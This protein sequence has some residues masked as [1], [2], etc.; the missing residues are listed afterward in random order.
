M[1]SKEGADGAMPRGGGDI[2]AGDRIGPFQVL[3]RIG[4]GGM[5]EVLRARD[6]KLGRDV[7]LKILARGTV[8]ERDLFARFEREAQAASALNHPNIITIFDTGRDGNTAYI[9]MELV[10]GRSLGDLISETK[11]LAVPRILAIAT[12]IADALATAHDKGIVHRDLKPDNVMVTPEGRVKLLDFGLAKLEL[13]RVREPG[14]PDRTTVILADLA[15]TPGTILGT[16]GYMAPEQAAGR[17]TDFRSDQFSFGALLYEMCSGK[18]AFERDSSV[19]TLT[20][21]IRDEPVS[22]HSHRED[23][24]PP[25]VWLVERCLAKQPEERYAS[26]RD[27]YRDLLSLSRHLAEVTGGALRLPSDARTALLAPPPG[28]QRVT[29][30]GRLSKLGPSRARVALLALGALVLGGALGALSYGRFLE[31]RAPGPPEIRTL[32]FSGRDRTPAVSPDG[33][34]VA[35][36]S[37]RDGTRRIWLKQIAG[38]SEAPL[39]EGPDDAWPG[40]SPDGASV[41]FHRREASGATSIFRAAVVGGEVRRILENGQFPSLSPDGRRLAFV[42]LGEPRPGAPLATEVWVSEADGTSPKRVSIEPRVSNFGPIWSPDGAQLCLGPAYSGGA[43]PWGIRLLDLATAQ[44]RADLPIPRGTVTLSSVVWNGDG[45]SLLGMSWEAQVGNVRRTL[46]SVPRAGGPPRTLLSLPNAGLRIGVLGPGRLVVDSITSQGSLIELPLEGGAPRRVLTRGLAQD[47]QPVYSPDGRTLA[48]SSDRDGGID[49]YAIALDTF[50]LRR[51]TDSP[52]EDWDPAYAPDGKLVF[53]SRRSGAFEIYEAAPDG[54]GVRPITTDREDAQNPTATTLGFVVYANQ[55]KG[56]VRKIPRGGGP[57]VTL[58]GGGTAQCEVSP[59]GRWVAFATQS[60][61][62]AT[63]VRVLSTENGALDPFAIVVE[64]G[65]DVSSVGL[66]RMR[67]LPGGK[68]IA[69]IGVDAEGRT[70][71]F[72]QDFVPGTDTA[73]TRRKLAGFSDDLATESFA[74]SPD[75]T[76]ITISQSEQR[77]NLLLLENVPGVVSIRQ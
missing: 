38:G 72:A 55:E 57:A 44:V 25:L 53:S 9:A 52:A 26:T 73:T 32:T 45:R 50:A 47:R 49:L 66:G 29:E 69:F 77:W 48:F 51:L 40:F 65:S 67:W 63:R 17:D 61:P 74:I 1:S 31:S 12:Q 70:G 5:G 64:R 28:W 16:V 8:G 37:S 15:T 36:V 75:G 4:A 14:A 41:T 24:P 46:F 11:T 21:I 30:T 19:E 10:P 42:R 34:T 22:L 7:A 6:P 2:R 54:S 76:R 59:D 13:P 18:R 58:Y 71:V 39:T 3:G 62:E 60:T 35:F 27:L 43:S 56:L 20:A 33:R 23:L 68:A